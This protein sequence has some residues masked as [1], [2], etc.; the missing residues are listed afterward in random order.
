M[1]AATQSGLN[2][3]SLNAHHRQESMEADMVQAPELDFLH[4]PLNQCSSYYQSM[5]NYVPTA[6]FFMRQQRQCLFQRNMYNLTTSPYMSTRKRPRDPEPSYPCA[7]G[8]GVIKQNPPLWNYPSLESFQE[9][10]PGSH[11]LGNA[12]Y[13]SPPGPQEELPSFQCFKSEEEPGVQ[14]H[15]FANTLVQSLPHTPSEGP[16]SSLY[17][18]LL[19]S[20]VYGSSGEKQ[21]TDTDPETSLIESF[22]LDQPMNTPPNENIS[23]KRFS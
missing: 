12:T 17:D 18:G 7:G 22:L 21:A 13:S 9:Q 15:E 3:D 6:A 11:L 16:S 19:E 10:V 20:A 5:I 4:L 14:Q 23:G 8:Y 1:N 2:T